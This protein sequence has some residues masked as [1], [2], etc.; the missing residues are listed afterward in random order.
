MKIE[1]PNSQ[2]LTP[3]ETQAL[4]R[5]RDLIEMAI[6]DGVVTKDEVSAIRTTALTAKP[7]YELLCQELA[8]Y[9]D[10]IT[11]K[12]QAGLLAAEQFSE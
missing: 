6:A 11:R 9:R 7:R 12:V 4:N 5:L 10:L 8:L 1:R 2:E 3:E